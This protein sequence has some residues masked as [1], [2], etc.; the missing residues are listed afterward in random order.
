MKKSRSN[1]ARQSEVLLIGDVRKYWSE[2]LGAA[3]DTSHVSSPKLSA[4]AAGAATSELQQRTTVR[5]RMEGADWSLATSPQHGAPA[6]LT[7]PYLHMGI[8]D[9]DKFG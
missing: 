9:P 6:Y 5:G 3:V 7:L 2:S 1:C 4:L 8:T